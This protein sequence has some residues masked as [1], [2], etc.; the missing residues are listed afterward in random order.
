MRRYLWLK[1]T[2]VNSRPRLLM[3]IES[4]G[5]SFYEA[6]KQIRHRFPHGLSLARTASI[7]RQRRIAGLEKQTGSCKRIWKFMTILAFDA[8]VEQHQ[9]KKRLSA[10]NLQAGH[11]SIATSSALLPSARLRCQLLIAAKLLTPLL[12]NQRQ[13]VDAAV[14]ALSLVG[15]P[16]ACFRRLADELGWPLNKA[17]RIRD[18]GRNHYPHIDQKN[19]WRFIIIRIS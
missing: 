18:P 1:Q 17:R 14:K 7:L 5:L 11:C 12:P 15:I 6:A 19:G 2:T 16:E 8:L 10:A 9:L 3:E 13:R 4:R